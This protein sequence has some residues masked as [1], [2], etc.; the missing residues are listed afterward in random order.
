MAPAPLALIFSYIDKGPKILLT[1]WLAFEG[2][3][4]EYFKKLYFIQYMFIEPL[5]QVRD[6]SG[7]GLNQQNTEV[8]CSGLYIP[9]GAD[10]DKWVL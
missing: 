7:N 5:L 6:Y 2:S 10:S 8:L 1:G 4:L 3:A 9:V